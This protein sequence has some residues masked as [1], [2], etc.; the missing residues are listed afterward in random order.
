KA[1]VDFDQALRI[2]PD[3]TYA[4]HAR[5]IYY[6]D[7][8]ETD[9]AVADYDRLIRLVPNSSELYYNRGFFLHGKGELDRAVVDYEQAIRRDPNNRN[10]G[11]ELERARSSLA[12]QQGVAVP[13]PTQQS[14]TPPTQTQLVTTLQKPAEV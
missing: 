9:R 4:L 7:S 2:D 12:A 14:T 8:G 6:Q 3:N 11:R 1:L 5:I 10:A 13:I